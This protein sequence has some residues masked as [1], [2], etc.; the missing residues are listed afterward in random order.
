MRATASH[1]SREV[2]VYRSVLSKRQAVAIIGLVCFLPIAVLLVIGPSVFLNLATTNALAVFIMGFV[3]NILGTVGIILLL[4]AWLVMKH[5]SIP[6][7][8]GSARRV[9]LKES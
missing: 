2:G 8:L 7:S 5:P 1:V 6:G 3:I 9:R 4:V